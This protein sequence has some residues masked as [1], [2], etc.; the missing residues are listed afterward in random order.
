VR[1]RSCGREPS[2]G[3][4]PVTASRSSLCADASRS[5]PAS[6]AEQRCCAVVMYCAAGSRVTW[7]GVVTWP[8]ALAATTPL[9]LASGSPMQR[10]LGGRLVRLH[11][12]LTARRTAP[13]LQGGGRGGERSRQRPEHAH[14]PGQTCPGHQLQAV[15]AAASWSAGKR[16]GMPGSGRLHGVPTKA[17]GGVRGDDRGVATGACTGLVGNRQ[18]QVK[19]RGAGLEVRGGRCVWGGAAA[20]GGGLWCSRFAAHG[21]PRCCRGPQRLLGPPV[22]AASWDRAIFR[23]L[24]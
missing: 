6:A 19:G 1:V 11:L 13:R 20:R 24:V 14:V 3:P 23:A 17:E 15:P 7:P 4:S 5:G 8:G 22:P 2:G 21:A 12:L 9:R 18:L 16:Q 10:L